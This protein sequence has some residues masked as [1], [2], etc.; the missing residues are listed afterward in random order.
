MEFFKPEIFIF[1]QE[2]NIGTVDVKVGMYRVKLGSKTWV[3]SSA[4]KIGS[5]ARL[6]TTLREGILTKIIH[7]LKDI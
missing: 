2:T 4:L 7:F 1:S 3:E 6:D 5:K